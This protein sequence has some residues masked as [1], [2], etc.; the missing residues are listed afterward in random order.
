VLRRRAASIAE[1]P[2]RCWVE[3][4]ADAGKGRE[5]AVAFEIANST[6]AHTE[7]VRDLSGFLRSIVARR[8][9]RYVL[10]ALLVHASLAELSRGSVGT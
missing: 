1:V 10:L 8:C 2:D 3:S 4:D 5:L 7:E 9:A 6:A